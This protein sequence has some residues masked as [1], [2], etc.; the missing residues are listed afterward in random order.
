M[1][2]PSLPWDKLAKL[3]KPYKVAIYVGTLAIL[4]AAFYFGFYKDLSQAEV[5]LQENIESLQATIAKHRRDA[6]DLEKYRKEL[7][8]VLNQFEFSK[9]LL[10]EKQEIDE[11]LTQISTNARESGLI[12]NLFAPKSGE[13]K[14]DFYAEVNFEI[15]LNGPYLNI[16]D[17]YYDVGN[18]PRV[19]NFSKIVL[20]KPK[21]AGDLI[22]LDVAS[23]GTTFRFLTPAEL[24]AQEEARKQ[25]A[26]KKP[27]GRR[28]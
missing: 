11:L 24:K 1:K 25:Q 9:K 13:V 14:K 22:L 4:V 21:I 23:T 18:M 26:K 10:P 28:K 6:R 12:V 8:E 5:D 15:K 7:A 27:K 20:G 17:F 16:A 3:K 2:L 19:V